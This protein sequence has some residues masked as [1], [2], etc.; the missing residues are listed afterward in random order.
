MNLKNNFN[1]ELEES[2]SRGNDGRNRLKSIFNSK[3]FNEIE[4]K[5]LKRI[6]SSK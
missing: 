6:K 1:K 4:K 2:L 3:E 5:L